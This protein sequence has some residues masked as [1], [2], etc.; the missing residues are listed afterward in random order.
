[1]FH[2]LPSNLETGC[3]VC[4]GPVDKQCRYSWLS[5]VLSSLTRYNHLTLPLKR[6]GRSASR[7]GS[8]SWLSSSLTDHQFSNASTIPAVQVYSLTPLLKNIDVRQPQHVKIM[9]LYSSCTVQPRR[10]NHNTAMFLL[11]LP[12]KTI[13]VTGDDEDNQGN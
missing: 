11:D 2:V 6:D 4:F 5:L 10:R 12:M 1:M 9:I 13:R 7:V 3:N 8:A